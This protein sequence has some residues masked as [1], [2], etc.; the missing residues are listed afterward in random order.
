MVNLKEN[1]IKRLRFPSDGNWVAINLFDINVLLISY[2]NNNYL[3][4]NIMEYLN[5]NIKAK[6]KKLLFSFTYR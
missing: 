5:N 6:K 4:C 3:D 1:D 2:N